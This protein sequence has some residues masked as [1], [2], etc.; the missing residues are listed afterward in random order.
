[1]SL[2]VINHELEQIVISQRRK[3]SLVSVAVGLLLITFFALIGLAIGINLYTRKVEAIVAYQDETVEEETIE[4]VKVNQSVKKIPSSP[5]STQVPIIASLQQSSFALP[6]S[7]IQIENIDLDLIAL[8][9]TD[10]DGMNSSMTDVFGV[11]GTG[12]ELIP[13]RQ[14]MARIGY[15]F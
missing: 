9:V 15:T 12:I 1:M 7:E 2:H 5:S 11:A 10:K 4:K 13:P 8:N 14:I 3:S 6:V